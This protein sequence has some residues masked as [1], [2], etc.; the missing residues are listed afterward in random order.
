MKLVARSPLLCIP[1]RAHMPGAMLGSC[2]TK[3]VR[4]R[5]G[6]ELQ[7]FQGLQEM[8]DWAESHGD[9]PPVQPQEASPAGVRLTALLQSQCCR[10]CVLVVSAASTH[11]WTAAQAQLARMICAWLTSWGQDM[12]FWVVCDSALLL[13]GTVVTDV[14]TMQAHHTSLSVKLHSSAPCDVQS[15]CHTSHASM[16]YRAGHVGRCQV[17]PGRF[18]AAPYQVQVPGADL[19]DQSGPGVQLGGGEGRPVHEASP[20]CR[21]ARDDHRS[22]VV[23]S[24]FGTVGC[25][26]GRGDSA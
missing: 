18:L 26:P 24:C 7:G 4:M 16:R 6:L 12:T 22:D 15:A 11:A 19:W 5:R 20:V 1:T 21:Y 9:L 2:R 14:S 25:R 10:H 8:D 17:S 23:A 13:A 3:R